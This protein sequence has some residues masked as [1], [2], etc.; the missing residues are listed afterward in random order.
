[1]EM[2]D[3]RKYFLRVKY[4]RGDPGVA[5]NPPGEVSMDEVCA[6]IARV[7]EVR[8]WEAMQLVAL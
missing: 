8:G 6:K 2:F 5:Q 7:N 3:P 1:M 4:F